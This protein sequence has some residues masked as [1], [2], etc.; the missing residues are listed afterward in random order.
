VAFSVKKNGG[1]SDMVAGG[2]YQQY[3]ITNAV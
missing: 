2:A 3:V 1:S